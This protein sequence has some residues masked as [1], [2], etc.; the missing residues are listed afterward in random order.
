M[1]QKKIPLKIPMKKTQR[2]RKTKSQAKPG[3]SSTL[4]ILSY[5]RLVRCSTMPNPMSLQRFLAFLTI[6]M[7]KKKQSID[8]IPSTPITRYSIKMFTV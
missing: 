6:T 7:G 2:K 3:R 4:H 5:R 1:K 8:D